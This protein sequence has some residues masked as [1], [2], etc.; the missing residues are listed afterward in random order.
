MNTF[1]SKFMK[2]ATGIEWTHTH[3]G[4]VVLPGFTFNPWIGC[5]EVKDSPACGKCYARTLAQDRHKW[6]E[7]G[8]D[9]PRRKTKPGNWNKVRSWNKEA[10][11]K[12]VMYKV[13]CAS[14]SDW[15]DEHPMV[16]PWR[17][18][19]T[20][21]IDSCQNLYFLMLTKRI[22][23]LPDMIPEYWANEGLPPNVWLGVTTENQTNFNRRWPLLNCVASM[24]NASVTFLS[25]E[26]QFDAVDF[27]PFAETG[28]LSWV[29]TGGES[30][31]WKRPV[32]I[33]R[34]EWYQQ[35]RD[36]S[37]KYGIPYFHKQH[38]DWVRADQ[39]K[40]T[41]PEGINT[42][43]LNGHTYFHVGKKLAGNHLDGV[44]HTACPV[45]SGLLQANWTSD[46]RVRVRIKV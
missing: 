29:I 26:P 36:L 38:G 21:L 19:L 40:E 13:F 44:Q 4:D 31:A 37:A 28:R 42:K 12:G 46:F 30:D 9:T 8:A 1:D 33:S 7:W 11:K 10:Q 14:L 3:L 27:S 39:L 15:L 18:E 23:N 45:N 6:V 22:E 20:E 24:Y 16:V 35:A 5:N 34:V 43:T 41:P 2:D 25:I 17:N 32:R